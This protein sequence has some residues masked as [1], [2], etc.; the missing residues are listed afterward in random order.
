MPLSKLS[1][2]HHTSAEASAA[3]A[4]CTP[5]GAPGRKPGAIPPAL[6]HSSATR[7]LKNRDGGEHLIAFDSPKRVEISDTHGNIRVIKKLSNIP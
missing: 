2:L 3:R 5:P 4:P 1:Q 6:L 7:T